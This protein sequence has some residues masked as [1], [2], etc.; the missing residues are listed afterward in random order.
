MIGNSS[1]LVAVL[2]FAF[3]LGYVIGSWWESR[4]REHPEPTVLAGPA[5]VAIALAAAL[6]MGP[7]FSEVDR[8]GPVGVAI[9][10]VVAL[11]P[12][13][14][15]GSFWKWRPREHAESTGALAGRVGVTILLTVALITGL[16]PD[17]RWTQEWVGLAEFLLV[18]GLGYLAGRAPWIPRVTLLALV[19]TPLLLVASSEPHSSILFGRALGST[20]WFAIFF[21]AGAMGRRKRNRRRAQQMETTRKEG[22]LSPEEREI[23]NKLRSMQDRRLPLTSQELMLLEDFSAKSG[24]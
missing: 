2:L 13:L 22:A 23:L 14:V 3:L 1:I 15:L 8:A 20:F 11:L 24:E 10:L 16:V 9:L 19:L 4:P 12:G 18:A 21:F 7:F 5:G 6:L 17:P